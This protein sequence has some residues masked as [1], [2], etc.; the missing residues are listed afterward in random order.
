MRSEVGEC[1]IL[2][3]DQSDFLFATPG[4]PFFFS[5]DGVIDVLI[6]LEVNEARDFVSGGK[7]ACFSF[8]MLAYSLAQTI[9]HS[10]VEDVRAVGEDVDPEVIFASRHRGSPVRL[11]LC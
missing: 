4:F 3:T 5:G 1:R 11:R 6:T 8:A 9:R 2:G 10:D 7:A